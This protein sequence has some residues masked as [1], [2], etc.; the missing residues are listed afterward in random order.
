MLLQ[1]IYV[2]EGEFTR[3]LGWFIFLLM[4]LKYFH[5]FLLLNHLLSVGH[6]LLTDIHILVLI[7]LYQFMGCQVDG[8]CFYLLIVGVGLGLFFGFQDLPQLAN[9]MIK[10][11]AHQHF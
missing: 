11:L 3:A 9:F 2:H 5:S 6:Y 1:F 10:L 4:L 8:E 7:C